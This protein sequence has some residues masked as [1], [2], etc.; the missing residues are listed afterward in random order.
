MR[1]GKARG[2]A[3]GLDAQSGASRPDS[4]VDRGGEAPVTLP[5]F[6][7][8]A[9]PAPL[10]AAAYGVPIAPGNTLCIKS[11]LYERDY[12]WLSDNDDFGERTLGPLAL[13]LVLRDPRR[14]QQH[15]P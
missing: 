8:W 12:G 3:S 11:R 2:A 10:S 14:V 6:G 5:P 9:P 1:P 7:P 4:E 13:E 15:Q